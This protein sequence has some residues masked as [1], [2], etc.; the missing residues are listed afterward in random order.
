M[1]GTTRLELATS[2]VTA[3]AGL[4]SISRLD[5]RLSATVGFVGQGWLAFV[6]RF[7]QRLVR[8]GRRVVHH[9]DGIPVIPAHRETALT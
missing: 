4:R 2:A 5:R 7:V 6:Q 8:A 9:K 3:T 1:A